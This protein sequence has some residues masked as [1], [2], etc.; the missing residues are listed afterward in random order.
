MRDDPEIAAIREFLTNVSNS[1][2]EIRKN[3]NVVSDTPGEL[4]VDG[5]VEGF[6]V[7]IMMLRDV[8]YKD[9]GSYSKTA[10]AKR[11]DKLSYVKMTAI[12]PPMGRAVENLLMA[13][14]IHHGKAPKMPMHRQ[15]KSRPEPSENRKSW[16]RAMRH[17]ACRAFWVKTTREQR[18]AMRAEA[19]DP[20]SEI[21]ALLHQIKQED[22]SHTTDPFWEHQRDETAAADTSIY[23]LVDKD[24]MLILDSSFEPVLC[25]FGNLFDLLYGEYEVAKVEEAVRKWTSLPPLPLPDTS[26]HMVND[27]I[28]DTKHPEMDLEKTKTL[29]ELEQRQQCVVHYGTWAMKGRHNP[30]M[31]WRTP[32]TKLVR[33]H[34]SK[35]V[36]NYVELLMSTFTRSVLGLGSE[37]VRFLL[38][39]LAPA[40]YRICCDVFD[41]LPKEQ[42]MH[43]AGP[44]FATVAVLG[45]NSYTQRH[46]DRTDVDFGF[47]GLM[48]L[49]KYQGNFILI[50]FRNTVANIMVVGGNLCFPQL[51]LQLPYRRGDTVIFRGSEMEH[52]VADWTGYRAF[53]LYTNHQP[54]RN[55]AYRVMGRLPPKPS[56]PWWNPEVAKV[57]GSQESASESQS[58]SSNLDS[59]HYSPCWAEPAEQEPEELYEAD[60]HGA[61]YIG[62][63]DSSGSSGSS[64]SL[65]YDKGQLVT[66]VP[67]DTEGLLGAQD[68]LTRP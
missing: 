13:Q 57:A 47:A 63:W 42:K 33:G 39:T 53:L 26:R 48:A 51:G 4:V 6:A 16:Y 25:R 35:V 3:R 54:V 17:D 32:D 30:D 5:T 19:Q 2:M 62:R 45:V 40:E 11:V 36:E 23:E 50:H 44:T 66:A 14:R 27:Y 29:D 20:P 49:G 58:R 7:R 18:D 12:E 41:A 10:R 64:G 15:T 61:G 37:P 60:V 68:R 67:D 1:E 43:M 52:F 38:S 55:Y 28:R 31:V 24:I 56:D 9:K 46:T 65:D 59:T 34:P 22:K 8:S 21:N